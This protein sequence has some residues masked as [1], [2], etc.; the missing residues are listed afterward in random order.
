LLLL[1][2]IGGASAAFGQKADATAPT[3]VEVHTTTGPDAQ[4]RRA[5]VVRIEGPIAP[6]QLYILRR[7]TKEAIENNI[8]TLVLDLD[9]PGGRLDVMLE[10]MDV[11]VE[12]FDGTTIAFVNP[13]A[14]SAGAFISV[15]CDKIYFSPNG[16]MGAAAAV[17][18][19]GEEIPETMQAKID[20][21]LGAKIRT[22]TAEKSRYRSDV[23]RAMSQTDW[24]FTIEGEV[25]KASGELLSL[26]A[27]EAM[28]LYGEPAV[29]LLANGIAKDV[30][31]L[32]KDFYGI[33]PYQVT[34]F[35][36]SWAERLAKWIDGIAPLLVTIGMLMIFIEFKTPS[37][38]V[39]GGLGILLVV[40][41]FFGNTVAGLAGHEPLVLFFVGVLIVLLEIFV[42]PGTGLPLIAGLL[43]MF[44][45]LFW[46]LA[47][48]WPTFDGGY[49]LSPE[50]AWDTFSAIVLSTA[51]A[52]AL[53][54]GLLYLL[55]GRWKERFM[56]KGTSGNLPV[57][58]LGG[59]QSS[60]ASDQLPPLGTE[61]VAVTELR[62]FG[63]IRIGKAE[64][65]AR[66]EHDSLPAGS[67]VSVV[68]Y[69]SFALV[70]APLEAT[71]S[72]L[73]TGK[74]EPV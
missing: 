1:T 71:V 19:T 57:A 36:V 70:V 74:A 43:M 46:S 23:I 53:L 72:P 56:S 45:A 7:A 54:I 64:Y 65:E 30:D 25:I 12:K 49:T 17:S 33:A 9:T 63:K 18:G 39:I 37:F 52:V 28:A 31:T 50:S 62:P 69:Q 38:G 21:Y 6:P 66:C 58:D 15:A 11:L 22:L 8:D 24:E 10:M 35:E 42:I 16:I 34:A 48:F 27:Q 14:I 47:D 60:T 5:S 51:L 55:P 29:P 68:A 41:A 61:A 67:A 40:V 20:S 59:G 73:E 32:L 4:Q 26:T 2:A 44:G 3:T 13:E